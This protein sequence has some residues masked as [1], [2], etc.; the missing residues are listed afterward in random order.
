MTPAEKFWGAILG[1]EPPQ[2]LFG[3]PRNIFAD[4][5]YGTPHAAHPPPAPAVNAPGQATPAAHQPGL[6]N[7]QQRDVP[8]K[9][10]PPRESRLRQRLGSKADWRFPA[11]EQEMRS[12]SPPSEATIEDPPVESGQEDAGSARTVPPPSATV[13]D[14]PPR[15]KASAESGGSEKW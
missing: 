8:G 10:P 1:Y 3:V 2:T 5:G 4:P 6:S 13:E 9:G 7:Q 14:A 11:A 12:G 15:S